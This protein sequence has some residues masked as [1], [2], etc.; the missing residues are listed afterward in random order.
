MRGRINKMKKYQKILLPILV[1]A[2]IMALI[3]MIAKQENIIKSG[4][5]VLLKC[6]PVDP[7]SLF[8]G[9]YVILN[10]TISSIDQKSVKMYGEGDYKKHD[11][12]YVALQ[13]N[14]KTG[15][16]DAAAVSGNIDDLK[17]DYS[18]VIKGRVKNS[19]GLLNIKYGVE[20]YFV[21]QGEGL[22]IEKDLENTTVEVSVTDK[23]ESAITRLFIS[24][25]EVEFY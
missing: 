25:K 20:S 10:Y 22:V 17:K 6:E 2:Q 15:V 1:A 13:K 12:I 9:D 16:H 5:K 14:S 23:G 11:Y 7:R 4:E 24:G 8:S 18:T 21:P 19:W 3:S